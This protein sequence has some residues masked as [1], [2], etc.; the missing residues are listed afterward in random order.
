MQLIG[1]PCDGAEVGI[2]DKFVNGNN[3]NSKLLNMVLFIELNKNGQMDKCGINT[4]VLPSVP[5]KILRY[6]IKNNFAY[7]LTP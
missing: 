5:N 6:Q 1:G 7:Y 4:Q 2:A 3:M